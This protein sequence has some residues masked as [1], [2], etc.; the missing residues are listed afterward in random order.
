MASPWPKRQKVEP[1]TDKRRHANRRVLVV[2]DDHDVSRDQDG[3]SALKRR[4]LKTL[5]E[6]LNSPFGEST[7]GSFS[8]FVRCR[9]YFGSQITSQGCEIR[10]KL[11]ARSKVTANLSIA[12]F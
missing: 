9:V 8:L 4:Q 10:I 6:L 2:D 5:H 11:N 3:G 7:L 12:R 1:L